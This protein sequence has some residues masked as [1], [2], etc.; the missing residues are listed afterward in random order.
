MK[1]DEISRYIMQPGSHERVRLTAA[2]FD[3]SEVKEFIRECFS[4]SGKYQET[5]C[6]EQGII[7]EI[8]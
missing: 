5:P 7:S 1:E 4:F 2:M 8:I 3:E 6:Q